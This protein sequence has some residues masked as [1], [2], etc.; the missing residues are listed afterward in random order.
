MKYRG[1]AVVVSELDPVPSAFRVGPNV[2]VMSRAEAAKV[3]DGDAAARAS[4]DAAIKR[5]DTE[6]LRQALDEAAR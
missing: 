1:R 4:I 3:M 2:V 6:R 5:F